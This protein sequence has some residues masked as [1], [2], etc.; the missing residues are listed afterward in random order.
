MSLTTPTRRVA[1]AV[2][3]VA[4]AAALSATSVAWAGSSHSGKRTAGGTATL[5][6]AAGHDP[7]LHLPAGRWSALLGREH[8]AVPAPHVAPALHVRQERPARRQRR[9]QPRRA[10]R[11]RQGQHAGHDQAQELH[12]VG[13]QARDESRLHV[14]LQPPEGE[15]EELGRLPAGRHARQ[16]QVGEGRR[17]PHVHAHARP[18]LLADLV[19]GQPAL[20]ADADPPARLGRQGRGRP[21]RG[22]RPHPPPAP[23]PSTPISSARPRSRRATRRIRSGRSSTGPGSCRPT[24]P[25][26]TPNSC[27]TR[28]TPGRSSRRSTSSS[29]SPSRRPRPSSTCCARAASTTATCRSPRSRRRRRS[30][31]RATRSALGL[32]GHQ[33][34]AVQLREPEVG[35]IFKQLYVRQAMQMLIDQNGYV[36]SL[37]KG[38][39]WPTNGPVP[40][41]PANDLVSSYVKGVPYKYN[42]DHGRRT[43]SSR[44]AGR[45]TRTAR[46]SA[47]ATAVTASRPGTKLELQ[48]DLR[49]RRHRREPAGAGAASRRQPRP[50]SSSTSLRSP[51]TRSSPRPLRA[52]RARPARGRSSTGA[53]AGSTASTRCRSATSSSCA[54]PAPT[55]APTAT[56][57]TTPTSTASSR[58]PGLGPMT[59]FQNYMAKQLPVLWMPYRPYQLSMIK[60]TLKGVTA[61]PDPLAHARGMVGLAVTVSEGR[62]ARVRSGRPSDH[63]VAG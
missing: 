52:R 35:P 44:T 22:L 12:V 37:F 24:A 57:R 46:A 63:R 62:P 48:H 30:R 32:V 4:V 49:L 5:A 58:R 51:S 47:P 55:S 59:T 33:L 19:H 38:Y 20:A 10:A 41:K 6:P 7:R 17:R 50:A 31:V 40:I 13:R 16:R 2:A 23:R 54:A 14:P 61:E 21:G 15:Q 45:S 9:R 11:L 43:C 60:K 3:A 28:S 53:A 25:T 56:R 36:K 29:S 18:R 34:H 26:A 27:R 39:G 1:R 42:P 8:R